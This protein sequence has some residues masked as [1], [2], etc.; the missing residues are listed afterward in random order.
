MTVISDAPDSICG[1]ASSIVPDVD[2]DSKLSFPMSALDSTEPDS[3]MESGAGSADSLF[4]VDSIVSFNRSLSLDALA[5]DSSVVNQKKT[6]AVLINRLSIRT[7]ILTSWVLIMSVARAWNFM[8]R[9]VTWALLGQSE[10]HVFV[11]LTTRKLYGCI[12]GN[13][14]ANVFYS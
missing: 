13:Y 8:L 2:L 5:L 11:T 6:T 1:W 4:V 10:Y 12:H 14:P 9:Q 7:Y 3:W